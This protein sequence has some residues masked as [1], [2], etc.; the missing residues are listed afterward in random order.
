M[1]QDRP[2]RARPG[3]PRGEL[4]GE[5]VEVRELAQFLRNLMEGTGSSLRSLAEDGSVHYGRDAISERIN[6]E[7]RPEWE[8][9]DQ[10]V[11]ACVRSDQAARDHMLGRAKRLWDQAGAPARRVAEPADPAVPAPRRDEREPHLA[12]QRA[13]GYLDRAYALADRQQHTI[14]ALQFLLG[15]LTTATQHLVAERD[16]LRGRLEAET[17]ARQAAERELQQ[18]RDVRE[19][20]A[21][22]EARRERAEAQLAQV[23]EQMGRTRFLIDKAAF[24]EI[25][26]RRRVDAQ[27]A[28]PTGTANGH[29]QDDD[30]TVPATTSFM[31][32]HDQAIAD[33]LLDGVQE[34]LEDTGDELDELDRGLDGLAPDDRTPPRHAVAENVDDEPAA[35]GFGTLPAIAL[36]PADTPPTTPDNPP[37]GTD[38]PPARTDI[39]PARTDIP[40]ARTDNPLVPAERSETPT[41]TEGAGELVDTAVSED[42]G[43]DAEDLDED[44][45]KPGLLHTLRETA[46]TVGTV[47]GG[48]VVLAIVA[49]VILVVCIAIW[50]GPD[51]ELAYAE[52]DHPDLVDNGGNLDAVAWTLV[53]G[54]EIDTTWKPRTPG[55]VTAFSGTL[56]ARNGGA[57]RTSCWGKVQYTL[58]ADGRSIDTGT[59]HYTRRD[60]HYRF[61]S[62]A[63]LPGTPRTV[64]VI[65]RRIDSAPCATR[66]TWEGVGLE[67]EGPGPRN[68]S[69]DTARKAA[70]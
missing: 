41:H 40:P 51:V 8:F 52:G 16:A 66:L 25:Q 6:G 54:K 29:E 11:R 58:Y 1:D 9:V 47:I 17:T 13:S 62:S 69:S 50:G 37:T 39:P 49:V 22:A 15:S 35:P 55:T 5:W 7:H 67:T 21:A 4:R 53:P 20:L 61:L 30:R 63:D 23:H 64:R 42:E 26:A 33:E 10:F 24:Q 43:V 57:D 34:L 19:R 56:E 32:R 44:P 65:A 68:G 12:L 59:L 3:R 70:G 27:A 38:I 48:L 14:G 45:P 60:S 46:V 2:R 31:D 18:L 36:I 28:D